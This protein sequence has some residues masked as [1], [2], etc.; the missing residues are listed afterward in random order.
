MNTHSAA[1]NG[2]EGR[3]EIEAAAD[4]E[5]ERNRDSAVADVQDPAPVGGARKVDGG[6][7]VARL[8]QRFRLVRPRDRPHRK[9]WASPTRTNVERSTIVPTAEAPLVAVTLAPA[10]GEL[11]LQSADEQLPKVG[12]NAARVQEPFHEK[13]RGTPPRW[14]RRPRRTS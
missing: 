10:S 8:L 12:L 13:G 3:P 14:C 5:L 4:H 11:G 2:T 1:G 6:R 7:A 9:A